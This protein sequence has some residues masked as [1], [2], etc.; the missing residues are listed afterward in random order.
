MNPFHSRWTLQ[1][2]Q[3]VTLAAA[4]ATAPLVA[5]ARVW[6]TTA[7][8]PEMLM[9]WSDREMETKSEDLSISAPMKLACVST[10]P[11]ECP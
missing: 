9:V 8:L 2:A 5:P 3:G 10:L 1:C 11:P 7:T 6:R 4:L